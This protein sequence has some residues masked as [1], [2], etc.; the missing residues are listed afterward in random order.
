MSRFLIA[1][2]LAANIGGAAEERFGFGV[3]AEAIVDHTH[4]VHHLRLQLG[5]FGEAG[6][7]LCGGFIENFAGADVV[8]AGFAG[9]GDFEHAG[10][11]F[12]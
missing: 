6:V 9:I 2:S 11:E 8:A 1:K 3:K 12:A 10:H 7:D 4:D 5:I